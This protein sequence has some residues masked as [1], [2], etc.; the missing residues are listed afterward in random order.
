MSKKIGLF[1]G[2]FDPIH[3]GH[4]IAAQE[5]INSKIVEEVW[6]I[7][8]YKNAFKEKSFASINHRMKLLKIA[9][10]G[11]KK[12]KALNIEAIKKTTNYTINTIKELKKKF[13]EKKFYWIIGS[14]LIK[15]FPKWKNAEQ[16][17]KEVKIIIVPM[18]NFKA[19][20]LGMLKK[21]LIVNPSIK[22]NISSTIIRERLK[23]GECVEAIIPLNV[24]N[25]IK[26]NQ[27]YK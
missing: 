19:K 6:F 17:L 10:K 22:T 16:I 23:K 8:C 1:G 9:L 11:F 21:A 4:L 24:L 27:L 3:L 15:E 25:Y 13:P 14:N 20:N 12:F 18:E 26:K 7:P 2:S 5:V